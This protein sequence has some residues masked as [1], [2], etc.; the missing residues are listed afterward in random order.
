MFLIKLITFLF[1]LLRLTLWAAGDGDPGATDDPTGGDTEPGDS[2]PPTGSDRPGDAKFTQADIDRF[3]GKARREALARWAK[4]NGFADVKDLEAVIKAKKEADD[5]AKTDLTKANERAEREATR[6][7]T[8]EK[9]LYEVVLKFGF[10][11]AAVDTVADVELAYLAAQ[12]LGLLNGE[13]PVEIDLDSASVK[14][15]D[16]VIE[17]LLKEKPLLKKQPTAALPAG[18]GGAAGGNTAPAGQMTPEQER[19]YRQ[20]YG[21]R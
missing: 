20:R 18:T 17:K 3:T 6:A 8:A 13:G 11:L 4:E 12:N 10:Q 21:I 1:P 9:R 14:G 5:K 7:E 15:M 2:D 16:K 19:A